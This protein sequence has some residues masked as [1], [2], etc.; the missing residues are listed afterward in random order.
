MQVFVYR[1][2][3]F[4]REF[5]ERSAA[6]GYDALVLTIDN[7]MI[8]NRERD[9]RNGFTIP[10]RFRAGDLAAMVRHLP[11]LM[12]MAPE[13]RRITFGNYVRPGQSTD[14]GTLAAQMGAMLDPGLSWADV[15]WLRGIWNGPLLLKGI[16]H[17]SEAAE[18]VRRGV[19]GIVVSNHGGRQL[20][21][22]AA[23]A[24]ALPAVVAAV[25]G[26]IPVLVDGGIRRGADVVRALAMGAAACLIA[27]PQLWGL[28][29]AGEAGVG[30]VLNLYRTEIDRV[31]GLCGAATI[32]RIGPDLIL[33][34]RAAG[35]DTRTGALPNS[36][37]G[38][39]R[40]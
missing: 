19:D 11:W 22:A 3:G 28:A 5:A 33:A 12:R 40:G 2:R 38:G 30:H 36:V 18:A 25:G 9:L 6:A 21:G 29:V 1:D 35:L 24:D 34:P 37:P 31:M 13:M 27:R 10:P 8:G 26:R 20:D 23:T 17:P 14:L 16:L 39:G 32:A 15:D 4:T 7:Q